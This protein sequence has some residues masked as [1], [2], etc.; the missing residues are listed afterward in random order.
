MDCSVHKT[1]G[2]KFSKT[3]QT[4]E[5][6]ACD[7]KVTLAEVKELLSCPEMLIPWKL[8]QLQLL[9]VRTNPAIH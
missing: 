4:P 3:S 1:H 2:E 6:K 9:G 5:T 8:C 7:N